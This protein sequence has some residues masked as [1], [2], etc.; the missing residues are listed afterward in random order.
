MPQLK[1]LTEQNR[2]L[3]EVAPDMWAHMDYQPEGNILHVT[4][5]FVPNELRGQGSGKVLMETCLKEIEAQGLKVH[6]ICSYV[7]HYMN[8]SK[9]WQ[10]L[11]A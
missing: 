4:H 1:H 7:V 6:P 8:R 11:L 5:T 9:D 10:H 2:F 3:V